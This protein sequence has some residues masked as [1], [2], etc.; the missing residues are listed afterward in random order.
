MPLKV[1]TAPV[2]SRAFKQYGS[3]PAPSTA[4]RTRRLGIPRSVHLSLSPLFSSLFVCLFVF[5][6]FIFPLSNG[7]LL[8]LQSS[9]QNLRNDVAEHVRVRA[10]HGGRGDTALGGKGSGNSK[11][12][13][14][15]PIRASPCWLTHAQQDKVR[16][17]RP[18]SQ[19]RG[20]P[21]RHPSGLFICTVGFIRSKNFEDTGETVRRILQRF[22]FLINTDDD[23]IENGVSVSEQHVQNSS[24]LQGREKKSFSMLWLL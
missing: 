21:A 15:N 10:S 7:L 19:G 5:C 6:I 4:E 20:P 14:R 16:S 13:P 8:S 9:L 17:R 22:P 2:G 1:G 12:F 3:H 23:H 18:P 24:G 11:V